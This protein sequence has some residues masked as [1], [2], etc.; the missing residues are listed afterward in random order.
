MILKKRRSRM[1]F[2][3]F[4]LLLSLGVMSLAG[5]AQRPYGGRSYG[6]QLTGTYTLDRSR[7]EDAARAIERA[8]RGMDTADADRVR[9]ALMRRLDAPDQIAIDQTG[10]RITMASSIAPQVTLTAD[11]RAITETRPN[12]RTVR[13][14]ATLNRS[15][16]SIS[17]LGD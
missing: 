13:T 9:N 12:G 8:I 5:F 14:A 3:G 10:R 11:G 6:G 17:S 15:T 7:S 1:K 16:L 2:K 4:F